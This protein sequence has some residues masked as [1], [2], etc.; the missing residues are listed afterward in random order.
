MALITVKKAQ[1]QNQNIFFQ[2]HN[3]CLLLLYVLKT[4]FQQIV[5]GE[6]A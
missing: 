1:Q 4:Q 3:T 2:M 6:T 5:V